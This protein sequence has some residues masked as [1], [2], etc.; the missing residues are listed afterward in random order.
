MQPQ[1]PTR[2]NALKSL[3]AGALAASAAPLYAAS[4]KLKL[5]MA[6]SW[7][8]NTPFLHDAAVYFA[9]TL[10]SAS[11]GSIDIRIYPAGALVPA[12]GVFDAVSAGQ[13]DIFHSATYYWGGK[14]SAFNVFAGTPFGLTDS[15]MNAWMRFG[16]GHA[17][18]ARVCEKYNLYPLLGG[19]TGYQMGGW[20]KKR[21]ESLQDLQ[22]L[23][24]RMP[25]LAAQIYTKLGAS[26]PL[27]PGGEIYLALE[28]GVIDATD[29]IAP[30]IDINTGFYKVA[31][32]Y[33]TGWHE[34]ASSA[35]FVFNKKV[36]DSLSKE[37]QMLITAVSND[38][39]TRMT[40]QF[41]AQNPAALQKLKEQGAEVVRFPKAVLD[42]AKK[43][44]AEVVAEES[45]KN[46]DFKTA[47][48]SYSGFLA[49]QRAYSAL[50]LGAYFGERD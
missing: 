31:K 16:G 48:E 37:Q 18:W 21:I 26:T 49:Q 2:R 11:N 47:W 7:A 34:P 25:G 5:K 13:I 50:T 32:Y 12:L 28:R 17:L 10:K 6:T 27:L 30:A 43:A 23:K 19:N 14:N 1:N 3:A 22:G 35:E 45:A 33:Y 24:I 29:W 41:Q 44:F 8:P 42:A 38:T 36:W 9:N 15:E 46:P 20:F 4:A 40:A 39:N